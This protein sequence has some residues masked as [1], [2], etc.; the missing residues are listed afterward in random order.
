MATEKCHMLMDRA[1]APAHVLASAFTTPDLHSLSV[2]FFSE[3]RWNEKRVIITDAGVQEGKVSGMRLEDKLRDTHR[4]ARWVTVQ[5]GCS[6][7][8]V[9]HVVCNELLF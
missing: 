3:G 7:G 2:K 5:L 9:S 8:H 6:L 1:E 4:G